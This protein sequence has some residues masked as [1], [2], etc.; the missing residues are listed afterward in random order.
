MEEILKIPTTSRFWVLLEGF[1]R[2]NSLKRIPPEG[3]WESYVLLPSLRRDK[4]FFFSAKDGQPRLSGCEAS[5]EENSS[6]SEGRREG[7]PIGFV[8]TRLVF[9][10]CREFPIAISF[11]P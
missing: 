8:L 3:F 1:F 4:E 6:F 5:R 11:I 10:L 7:T 2:R 9:F